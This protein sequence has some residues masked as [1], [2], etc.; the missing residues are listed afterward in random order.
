MLPLLLALV[1]IAAIPAGSQ[2]GG[3][4]PPAP[5][6]TADTG[7]LGGPWSALVGTWSGEGEGQPGSG[8]GT[9]TFA[10]ELDGHVLVRRSSSDYPASAGRPAVHH[11][12]LMVVYPS[13]GGGAAHAIYFD[14]EGH[15]IEY[16]ASWSEEGRL[17]SFESAARPGAP[18]FRLTYRVLAPDRLAVSFEIA[19]PGSA[20]FKPYVAG[21]LRR[22]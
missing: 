19:P 21:A 4:P 11:E 9:S 15:V 8:G 10:Y 5:G 16:Q 1:M 2:A 13:P 14:N 12:D 18:T 17:L 22:R 3:T 20:T 6:N 7:G